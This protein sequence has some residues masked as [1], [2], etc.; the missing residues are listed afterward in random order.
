MS[1]LAIG[2]YNRTHSFYNEEPMS[3]NEEAS[4]EAGWVPGTI[5][6]D[7]ANKYVADLDARTEARIVA[8]NGPRSPNEERIYWKMLE[9]SLHEEYRL[10]DL[11]QTKKPVEIEWDFSEEELDP[12]KK[13]GI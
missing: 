10:K 8:Q 5:S 12:K 7:E 9:R 3:S 2:P 4:F 6:Q 11:A 13:N 1:F